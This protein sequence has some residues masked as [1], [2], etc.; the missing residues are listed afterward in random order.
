MAEIGQVLEERSNFV[1]VRLERQEACAK[2][3]ACTAGFEVKDMLIEAENR[4][5]AQVNDYV[6]I[7]LE[8]ANFIKAV[9][10][11]YLLPFL[12]LLIGIGIGYGIGFLLAPKWVELIA[13]I[14]GF[15][16]TVVVFLVIRQFEGHFKSQ[17][18]RPIAIKIVQD[19][20][21]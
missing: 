2:C 4:C 6:E 7:Y 18:Y 3:R 16:L 5:N 17:Q 13:T 19:S 21:V 20:L 15:G 8:E 1:L 11:M 9:M 12:G 10:I 14:C